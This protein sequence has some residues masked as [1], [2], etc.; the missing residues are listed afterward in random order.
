MMPNDPPELWSDA[1]LRH[2][3]E[4]HL[5]RGP[6]SLKAIRRFHEMMDEWIERKVATGARGSRVELW[7]RAVE[8]LAVEESGR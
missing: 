2:E 5:R 8:E 7:T 3:L 4:K 6:H 1:E